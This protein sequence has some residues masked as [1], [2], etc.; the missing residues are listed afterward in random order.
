MNAKVLVH[1]ASLLNAEGVQALT[2]GNSPIAH[3]RFKQALELMSHA[4]QL[5]LPNS[6]TTGYQKNVVS[7]CPVPGFDQNDY[8]VCNNALL[9]NVPAEQ[10]VMDAA[11][12][13]NCCHASMFNLAL[14][15][16]QRGVLTGSQ[17]NLAAAGR[18]YEQCLRLSADLEG[19]AGE[20]NIL[21][22]ASLNNAAQIYYSLGDFDLAVE[23]LESVRRLV[24]TTDL[25][26][27][28]A[29]LATVLQ[30]DDVILNVLV[31]CK[32]ST[33]PCA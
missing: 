22:M 12:V 1:H 9:F 14:T 28:D 24:S 23:R 6:P 17:K 30:L 10:Q 26:E 3:Q 27:C 15:L 2:L 20:I 32:P 19:P 29:G 8:Y 4:T 16:H 11:A 21:A 18:L 13:A 7:C 25:T 33:A 5:N 31:T